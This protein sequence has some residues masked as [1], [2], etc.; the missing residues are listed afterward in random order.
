MWDIFNPLFKMESYD[1]NLYRS[2]IK[3]NHISKTNKILTQVCQ[4]PICQQRQEEEN[5]EFPQHWF[6][7]MP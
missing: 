6:T 1:A 7:T 3:S 5:G 2:L 4:H